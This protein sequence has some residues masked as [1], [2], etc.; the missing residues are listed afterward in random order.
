MANL[1]KKNIRDKYPYLTWNYFKKPRLIKCI[2]QIK[3]EHDKQG[4]TII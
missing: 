1:D 3:E 2:K 4:T